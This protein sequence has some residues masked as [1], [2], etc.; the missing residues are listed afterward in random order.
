[1]GAAEMPPRGAT[2]IAVLCEGDTE[3]WAARKLLRR[4]LSADGFAHVGLKP[5]NLRAKIDDIL[6]FT[7]QLAT[8]PHI[9]A[10]LTLVDLYGMNRAQLSPGSNLDSKVAAARRWL[11]TQCSR[12]RQGFFYGH[13]VVHE[14][15]A[16]I[17]AEGKALGT[18]LK[19]PQIASDP[20]AET[21][22]FDNPPKRRLNEM[23]RRHLQ[24]HYEENRDAPALFEV[25]DPRAVYTSCRYYRIIYDDLVQIAGTIRRPT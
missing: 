7:E 17:L 24:R 12:A 1:V 21:K 16:W 18:R 14:I 2:Q 5:I 3:E 6:I 10:V 8:D 11:A 15:E 23:F 20:D 22:D 19:H 9:C 25:M 4:H 13:V